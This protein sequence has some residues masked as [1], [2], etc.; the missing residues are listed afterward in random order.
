MQASL[1]V[2]PQVLSS[3]LTPRRRDALLFVLGLVLVLSPV[4]VTMG[5]VGGTDY[6]YESTEVVEADNALVYADANEVPPGTPISEEVACAGTQVERVCALEPAVV[7]DSLSLGVTSA[8]P[9]RDPAIAPPPYEFVQLD[10]EIYR[11]GYETTEDEEIEVTLTS[12]SASI[13]LHAVSLDPER[14]SVSSTVMEAAEEGEATSRTAVDVPDTPVITDDGYYRVY[15]A[16]DATEGSTSPLS[17]GIFFGA[18]LGG[19]IL[20]SLARHVRVSYQ[21]NQ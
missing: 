1:A 15:L 10:D 6:H 9:D 4:L 16:E 11:A 5:F 14:S 8:D 19:I 2:V 18:A 20:L 17:L 12:S 3:A 7:E 13:A 21:P